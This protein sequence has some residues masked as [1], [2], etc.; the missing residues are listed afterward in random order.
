MET[1]DD[2]IDS[3]NLAPKKVL[4]LDVGSLIE[5]EYFCVHGL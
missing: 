2:F 1:R 4:S 5:L 3:C